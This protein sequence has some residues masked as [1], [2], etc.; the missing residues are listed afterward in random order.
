M[1]T[2]SGSPLL[3]GWFLLLL[4]LATITP[5]LAQDSREL[6]EEKRASTKLKG[7]HPLLQLMSSRKSALKPEL[8]DVHPRVYVTDAELNELRDRARTTHKDCGNEHCA[9]CVHSTRTSRS[10]ST[11]TARAKRSG[12]RHRGSC[13]CLPDRSATRNILNAAKKFMDAAVSY[14]IWGY[15]NNKPNVDLAAGHLLYG[16]GWG[17]DL[18]YNELTESERARY[19]DKLIKQARLLADYFKPKSGRTFAY[20]QN[21]TF[22][23]MA[24][25]GVAAYALYGETPKRRTGPVWPARS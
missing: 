17:Y 2:V 1:R 9:G 7:E 19:R 5:F 10:T 20:S 23:P 11:K 25:L 15:A 21:H 4:A 14:D 6:Q 13:I 24:G 18:L 16:L 8:S 12:Y 22:I 3:A